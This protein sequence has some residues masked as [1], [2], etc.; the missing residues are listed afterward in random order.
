VRVPW[1]NQAAGYWNGVDLLE[2]AEPLS[3]LLHALPRPGRSD[4]QGEPRGRGPRSAS[5]GD[6]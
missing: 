2:K 4:G 3:A 1:A 6:R 5:S